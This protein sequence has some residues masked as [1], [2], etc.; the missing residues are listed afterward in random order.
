MKLTTKILLSCIALVLLFACGKKQETVFVEK[1]GKEYVVDEKASFY[2]PKDYKLDT[3]VDV[4]ETIQLVYKDQFLVYH[5]EN[6]GTDNLPE[7][8][9][10]L[11]MG[12][13]E[14]DG[15]SDVAMKNITITSGLDAQEFTGS[16]ESTGMHF[17]HVVYFTADKAYV[18]AYQAPEEVYQ[19]NIQEI[20]QYLYSLTVHE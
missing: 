8:L 15:A 11:Y 7:D 4:K 19:K 2:Y 20:S 5:M 10:A 13:L 9:P 16:F 18:Y 1:D 3:S 17:K 6:E 14:E 12:Q